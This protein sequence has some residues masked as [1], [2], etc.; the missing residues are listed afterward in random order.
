MKIR[1]QF[2]QCIRQDKK[3]YASEESIKI[4]DKQFPTKLTVA[5][6]KLIKESFY[7]YKRNQKF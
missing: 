5:K 7:F 6:E 4:Q 2:V 1:K 3:N